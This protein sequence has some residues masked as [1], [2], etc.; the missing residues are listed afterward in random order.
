M[1]RITERSWTNIWEAWKKESK[2]EKKERK[3]EQNRRRLFR[4]VDEKWK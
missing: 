3:K 1:E 2:G 4:M